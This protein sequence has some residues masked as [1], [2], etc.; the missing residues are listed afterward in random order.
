MKKEEKWQECFREASG[1]VSQWRK[2][3]PKATFCDIENHVDKELAK[4]RADM[5]ADLIKESEMQDFKGLSKEKRPKC[6]VCG[7]L[8]ASNGRQRR[9]LVTSHEQVIEVERS[10]GYCQRCRVSYFPP[11]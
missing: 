10:K 7:Q 1:E 4:V 6:P 8:L 9:E 11:R 5:I 3:H 2:K